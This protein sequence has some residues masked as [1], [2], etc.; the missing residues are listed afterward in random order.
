MFRG[1]WMTNLDYLVGFSGI[2]N[3]IG[4]LSLD[5]ETKPPLGSA[6]FS[7]LFKEAHDYSVPNFATSLKKDESTP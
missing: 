4:G 3:T 6:G 5:P 2:E 1:T 7:S